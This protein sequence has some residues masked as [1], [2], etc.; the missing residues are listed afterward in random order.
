MRRHLLQKMTELLHEKLS[1]DVRGVLFDVHNKLGPM[2][3]EQLYNQAVAIGLEKQGIDCQTE[4][5]FEVTFRGVQVGRYAVDVWV[6]GGQLLLEL[7]VA[8]QIWPLHQ[9]QA[10]SSLKVTDADLA[11]VVNFGEDRVAIKR[12]PNFVRDKSVTF[13]W[14]A[15]PVPAGMLYPDLVNQLLSVLHSVYFHL[16][17]GFLHQIYRR[18]TM[19]ELSQQDVGYEYIKHIPIFYQQHHLSDQAVRL[20]AVEGQTLVATVAMQ[21]VTE[22]MKQQLRARMRYLDYNLGLIANFHGTE[23]ETVFVRG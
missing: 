5:E 7:K 2:L 8:P 21:K 9:A 20:I 23:L 1:Y 4:K 18:A 15:Q 22:A 13:A 19:V 6:E 16:G 3:P 11:F 12:L 17:P 14:Q 10:I